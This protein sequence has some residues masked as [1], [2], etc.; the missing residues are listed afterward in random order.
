MPSVRPTVAALVFAVVAITGIVLLLPRRAPDPIT[1]PETP[2]TPP[3]LLPARAATPETPLHSWERL[4]V[5]D[6][7][8]R[9]D[10]AALADLTTNYLQ[11]IPSARRPA[12]GF[13]EDLAR[14]LTDRDTLGDAALPA[15]HPALVKGQLIDRW[16]TPWQVHPLAAD[17]LQLRSAG[18]DRRLYTADDLVAPPPAPDQSSSSTFQ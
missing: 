5:A 10:L 1:P 12:L 2:V 4:L 16:G 6:G 8:P 15:T 14:A 13:N 18:P 11:A 3:A 7:S 9:E 17:V